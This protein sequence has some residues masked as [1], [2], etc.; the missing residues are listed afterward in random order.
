MK[1][2]R[3]TWGNARVVG[4]VYAGLF[5]LEFLMVRLQLQTAPDVTTF[6]LV[7]ALGTVLIFACGA[8]LM[9]AGWVEDHLKEWWQSR[10][11]QHKSQDATV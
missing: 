11:N 3:S 9:G 10:G 2:I 4:E 6:F 7:P 5:F 8:L 1:F